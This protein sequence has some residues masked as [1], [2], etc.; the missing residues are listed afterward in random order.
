MLLKNCAHGIYSAI[1]EGDTISNPELLDTLN[2]KPP[3]PLVLIRHIEFNG[4]IVEGHEWKPL[5]GTFEAAMLSPGDEIQFMASP[6]FYAKDDDY[7]QSGL[8]NVCWV[9]KKSAVL[10]ICPVFSPPRT[11]EEAQEF[12]SARLKA[13][14]SARLWRWNNSCFESL[15]ELIDAGWASFANWYPHQQ[16]FDEVFSKLENRHQDKTIKQIADIAAW[17]NAGTVAYDFRHGGQEY[18][19]CSYKEFR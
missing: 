11:I 3:I 18:K 19:A 9:Q 12:L 8:A 10:E 5:W 7:W 2:D 14:K 6:R 4:E 1:Y 17:C 13:K 15:H 16:G